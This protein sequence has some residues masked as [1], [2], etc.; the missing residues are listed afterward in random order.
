MAR[1]LPRPLGRFLIPVILITLAATMPAAANPS[2]SEAPLSAR[3]GEGAL[4]YVRL[5]SPW[6]V[7]FAPKGNLFDAAQR[8]PA[9]ASIETRLITALSDVLEP[10]LAEADAAAARP[11]VERLQGP[12]EIA[13][14]AT[15]QSPLPQVLVTTQ[16]DLDSPAAID[17]ALT[18]AAA[19]NPGLQVQTPLAEGTGFLIV[20]SLPMRLRFDAESGRLFGMLGITQATVLDATYEALYGANSPAPADTALQAM[21]QRIDTSGQG[22]LLW[23]NTRA[24]IPLA[25]TTLPPEQ[26]QRLRQ[27]GLDELQRL[28]LGW[29][30]R[31]GKG[32]VTL[33]ADWGPR[34]AS[35]PQIAP[36]THPLTFTTRGRPRSVAGLALPPAD[37]IAWLRTQLRGTTGT[38]PPWFMTLEQE[39]DGFAEQ[40]GVTR[41]TLL[42]A[43]GPK[44]FRV[45]DAA[46]QYTVLEVQRPAIA[47]QMIDALAQDP[48]IERTQLRYQDR[49]IHGLH[50]PNPLAPLYQGMSEQLD[51]PVAS[52]LVP[53]ATPKRRTV[54]W[55]ASD[56]YWVMSDLPQP[57]M[58]RLDHGA[59]TRLADWLEA[60]QRMDL[61]ESL[62][63]VSAELDGVPKRAY[64]GY[65]NLLRRLGNAVDTP[66]QIGDL[67]PASALQL[68]QHGTY[69][70][71]LDQTGTGL[72]LEWT[73]EATP[74]DILLAANG[75]PIGLIAIGAVLGSAIAAYAEQQADEPGSGLMEPLLPERPVEP[76]RP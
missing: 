74:G 53:L 9:H 46:G 4:A 75:S 38:V 3:L 45:R 11:L 68:P 36:Q 5:P 7:L 59:P 6:A 72:A 47:E 43:V 20:E 21:D 17:Q 1:P 35:G 61:S 25:M 24:L 15:Q 56:G 10:V 8:T 16:L 34:S 64:Y 57:L 30:T 18:A 48:Q 67:P 13:A 42:D 40:A 41:E 58:D 66:V 54:Y 51:D 26:V 27:S 12:V 65:L 52:T 44:L 71:Q 28:A 50:F 69:G 39:L 70:L 60:E 32:R 14:R 62:A 23:L 76:G 31:D 2:E 33:L 19:R 63:Y 49:L 22:A 37:P 29:G 55:L 73:F